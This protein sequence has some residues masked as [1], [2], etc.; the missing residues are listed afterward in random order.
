VTSGR[1]EGPRQPGTRRRRFGRRLAVFG[2]AAI[3]VLCGVL[4]LGALSRTLATRQGVAHS[5]DV[6][7]ASSAV[8]N[9]LL[10][11][12]TGERGFLLTHDTVFLEPFRGARLRTDQALAQLRGLVA[13]RAEEERRLDTLSAR[14]RERLAS[15]DTAIA[16]EESGRAD[17]AIGIVQH[18]PGKRLMDEARRHIAALQASEETFL[19]D[20]QRSEDAWRQASILILA[21]GTLIAGLLALL[22]NRNFDR[23]LV[24]RRL[25]LDDAHLANERLQDQAVELEQQAE[26]AQLAAFEAEQATEQAQA[27]LHAAEESERRAERLQAATEALSGALS[28]GDVA[29]LIIDQAVAAL[30]A[31]SGALAVITDD[32]SAL[33][34]IALRGISVLNVG[35]TVPL[36][37]MMPLPTAMRERRSIILE[38]P[39][40]IR[41]GFPDVSAPHAVDGVQAIAAIPMENRGRVLGALLIRFNAPHVFSP[42]DRSFMSA[43]SRIAAEAFERARLF[44][45]ERSARTAA[46]SANRA[47]A[48]FLASMSHELRTPLQAALGFAQLLRSGVFGPINEEQSE[49]LSRVERSQTHLAR[50][51]DDILDFARLEAGRV[52][53]MLEAVRVSEIIDDLM[54]LVEPQA[55]LKNIS[56][57]AQ[58]ADGLVVAVDRQRMRQI[59]LNLVGNAIK[60]TNPGGKVRVTA[61]ADGNRVRLEVQD[62]GLGI[63]ADRIKEIFEPFVQVDDALTRTASGAGLGLAISRDLA[64]AMGGDLSVQSEPGR[65]SVFWVTFPAVSD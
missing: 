11:A 5:R 44:D 28:L 17:A 54:P 62:T 49:A 57:S 7:E 6:L 53:V 55:V 1:A 45:A 20:R 32:E 38:A 18:G 9:A 39:G 19:Q 14:A 34:F 60:F 61:R 22:V 65:G 13:G 48:A 43:L 21:I 12:E 58:A 4:S 30:A 51:I 31:S 27:A 29:A 36:D 40:Q 16:D 35:D 10:D 63:P 47:K 33:R 50:L 3:V 37:S 26:A 59:M 52:R 8:L 23:A 24:D 41:E 46:E 64:R 42:A 15:L 56:L 25:A 2:P